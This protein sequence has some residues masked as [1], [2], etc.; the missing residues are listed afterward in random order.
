MVDICR[1][2]K[3]G[4]KYLPLFTDTKGNNFFGGRGVYI[5]QVDSRNQIV[6]FFK[7]IEQN[8]EQ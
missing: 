6:P 8:P 1:D 7:A 3:R 5:K 4:G 2:A